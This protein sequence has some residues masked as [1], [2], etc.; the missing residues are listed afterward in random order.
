MDKVATLRVVPQ[1]SRGGTHGTNEEV[2]IHGRRARGLVET[3]ACSVRMTWITDPDG[4]R[5][6]IGLPG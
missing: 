5:I 3:V 6:H 4:N 2:R 1:D